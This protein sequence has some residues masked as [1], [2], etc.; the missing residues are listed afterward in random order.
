LGLTT[1]D[2]ITTWNVEAVATTKDARF[3]LG[4]RNVTVFKGFFIEPDIPVSVVRND[5]FP[6]KILIYNFD[7]RD[8]DIIIT[9]DQGD[10]YELLSESNVIVKSVKSGTVSSVDFRIKAKNVGKFMVTV[11]GDNGKEI[12]E[13][14]K[15]MRVEPDGKALEE[16]INGALENNQS[17]NATITLL[18]ERIPNSEDAYIKLQGGIEAITLDGA[19]NYIQFVSGC[20]EQSTSKLAVN[21]AAYNN[22]L[23]GDITDEQMFEFENMMTQGIEHEMIY[24][25]D[26]SDGTGKSVVWHGSGPPDQ[27]LT[28]WA[29]FAFQ[30]LVDAGFIV[31]DDIIPGFQDYLLSTQNDDGSFE[32]ENVGH[33]SINSK[34]ARVKLTSTAYIARALL[35]SGYSEDDTAIQKSIGYIENN[36]DP[37][38]DPYTLALTLLALEMGDGSTTLREDI[39]EKLFSKKHEDTQ[40]GTI[41]WSWTTSSSGPDTYRSGTNIIETTGYAIMALDLHGF[42]S[43]TVNKAVKY[44]LTHREGGCFGSTHDTAVAFQALNSVDEFFIEDLTV[45][46]YANGTEIRAIRFTDENKDIT[47]L[48]DLRPYLEPGGLEVKLTSVGIGNIF[49]QI[50]YEQYI[51]WNQTELSKPPELILNITYDTTNIKVNDTITAEVSLIYNGDSPSLK[52]VLID[53]R[54]PVGFSFIENEFIDLLNKGTINNYEIRDR[55]TMVYIDDIEKGKNITFTYSLRADKP[56]KGTIQGNHAYDMYNPAMDSEVPPVEVESNL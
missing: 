1:P 29:V 44:L 9:L 33:W 18:D 7:E 16:L 27:W 2:S 19:E 55:Q 17:M 4:T 5:E 43:T 15:E 31:D 10:W 39:A 52:M 48:I 14:I 26:N 41:W 34:L 37:D 8:S 47:Y 54:A 51:P 49:Y 23:K 38:G 13:V 28:A 25:I 35:Y 56:I 32:F 11:R 53:L 21:I 50:Y 3:G 42:F 6:L 12:D 24:V 45:T 22:L 40:E 20:G 36:V 46:A 30:D